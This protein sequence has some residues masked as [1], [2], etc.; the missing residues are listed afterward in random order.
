[1]KTSLPKNSK[2]YHLVILGV[3]LLCLQM[4]ARAEDID[5]FVGSSGGK[6]VA[7]N[8][9]FLIDNGPN[10]SRQAQKWPDNGGAQGTAELAAISGVLNSIGAAQPMNVGLAMLNAV[11]AGGG[12][13]GYLRFGARDMSIAA[14]RT[15]LQ[16]MLA[17]IGANVTSP[18][19]KISGM[20]NKDEAAG[21][22][23]VYKYFNG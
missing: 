1:M 18:S 4:H 15:A 19:E 5:I 12:G 8:V 16:N 3:T 21:L 17:H 6:A 14:H 20:A 11:D 10:W 23:E 13:G 22:Y 2:N 9:I 7:S